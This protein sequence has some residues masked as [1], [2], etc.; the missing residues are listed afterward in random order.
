MY[1][2]SNNFS[3][4]VS[5][6]VDYQIVNVEPLSLLNFRR[7]DILAK[8]IYSDFKIKGIKTN[9][10]ESIY[11]EHIKAFN[12]FVENDESKKVGPKAFLTAFDNIIN[13]LQQDSYREDNPIPMSRDGI[14]LDGAHRLGTSLALNLPVSTVTLD[15]DGPVYD[16]NFFKSR[17]LSEENLGFLASSYAR[18]KKSSRVVCVWPRGEGT[19]EE[20]TSI[21]KKHS[22]IVYKR[23]LVLTEQGKLNIM[24]VCYS[25]E[26]W[27]GCFSDGFIGAKNKSAQCFSGSSE[28]RIYLVD[29]KAD[30]LIMKDEIRSLFNV[31]K[32][33]IHVNDTHQETLDLIETLFNQNTLNLLN[34]Q[35]PQF[36]KKFDKLK[37]EFLGWIKSDRY[38][39]SDFCIDGSGTLAVYGVRDVN[40]LDLISSQKSISLIG[41][42][43]DVSDG[44]RKHHE[45]SVDEIIHNPN[46]HL[47]YEGVKYISLDILKKF[48]EKRASPNDIQDVYLISNLM[49]CQPLILPLR[50]KLK[51]WLKPRFILGKCKLIAL[52]IRYII[53][54]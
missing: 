33:S 40:D 26:P 8:Y 24:R 4:I 51:K 28:L 42:D 11:T 20:L 49:S 1:I 29:P 16:Y 39:L 15:V 52:R 50:I 36:F 5:E 3:N 32:H 18:L 13:S 47:I 45:L 12:N 23:S 14:I 54:K 21:I 38:D 17:G 43:I 37:N 48:K 7:L 19:E 25:N 9:F 6:T 31:G 53:R 27:L 30:L 46:N 44:K 41:K 2:F 35:E 10:S 22:E 34:T